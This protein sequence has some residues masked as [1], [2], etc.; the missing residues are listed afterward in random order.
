MRRTAKKT[1]KVRES[2]PSKAGGLKAKP[3]SGPG[4]T[5]KPIELPTG[6][7]EWISR[8]AYELWEQRGRQ[9]GSALRNWLEAE[10][11]VMEEIHEARK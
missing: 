8:K 7:W 3:S 5:G 1:S 10:E 4:K 9:E 2:T 6:M 11:I